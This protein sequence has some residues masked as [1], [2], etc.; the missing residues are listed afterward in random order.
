MVCP[1]HIDP[2]E[3]PVPVEVVSAE[4]KTVIPGYVDQPDLRGQ[5]G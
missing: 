2:P 3:L 1:E 5:S 4:G